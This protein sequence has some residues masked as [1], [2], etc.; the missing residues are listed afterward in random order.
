MGAGLPSCRCPD[1]RRLDVL[2]D[3]GS[4]TLRPRP[5][6]W[7]SAP[8]DRVGRLIGAQAG[9]QTREASGLNAC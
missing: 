3:M 6:G 5:R 1:A 4:R 2:Q 7:D 9:L 8:S